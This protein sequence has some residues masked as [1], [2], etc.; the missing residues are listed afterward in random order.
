MDQQTIKT[1]ANTVIE[2]HDY[3]SKKKKK[4]EKK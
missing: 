1:P 2:C 4:N 3:N